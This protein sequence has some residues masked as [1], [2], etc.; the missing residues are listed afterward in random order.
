V[1]L[2]VK[3][4]YEHALTTAQL[5]AKLGVTGQTVYRWRTTQSGP[6]FV[7]VPHGRKVQYLYPLAGLVAWLEAGRP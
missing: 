1:T 3:N 7:A 4:E 2:S 6:P 5:A